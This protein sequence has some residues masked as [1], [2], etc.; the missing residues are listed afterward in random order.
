LQQY[1]HSSWR[2]VRVPCEITRKNMKIP[3]GRYLSWKPQ[4]SEM[5][6]WYG[7]IEERRKGLG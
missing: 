3:V 1:W 4:S 2:S 6:S 7:V 5:S